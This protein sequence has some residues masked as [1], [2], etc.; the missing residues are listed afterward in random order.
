[1]RTK[2]ERQAARERANLKRQVQVITPGIID[3]W[4]VVTVCVCSICGRLLGDC[5]CADAIE[6]RYRVLPALLLPAKSPA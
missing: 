3:T 2:E 1:M 4:E 5:I 6:V